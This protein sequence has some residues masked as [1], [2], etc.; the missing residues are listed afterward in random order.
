MRFK[1]TAQHYINDRLLEEGV[2]IGEGT[3]VP[4]L[5]KNGDSLPPSNFMEGLDEPSQAM[6]DAVLR[7]VNNLFEDLSATLEPAG[8]DATA[9]LVDPI[10]PSKPKGK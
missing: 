6:V 4:F 3:D 9:R 10:D 2:I 8:A 5:D 1:L 7:R